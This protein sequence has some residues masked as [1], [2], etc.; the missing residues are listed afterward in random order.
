MTQTAQKTWRPVTLHRIRDMR[1]KEGIVEP[2]KRAVARQR[3][4]KHVSAAKT[5]PVI[6]FVRK[7]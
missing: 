7:T 2:E 1:L 6:F 3:F 5:L 4:V